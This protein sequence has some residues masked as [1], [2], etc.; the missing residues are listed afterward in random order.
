MTAASLLQLARSRAG[1]SQ[2]ELARRAHTSQA[3]LS[4]IEGGAEEP[5]FAQLQRLV[6]ACG[7][8]LEASVEPHDDLERTLADLARP[9][10]L[11]RFLTG[12]SLAAEGRS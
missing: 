6:A 12:V 2:R 10:E 8:R 9:A 3:R 4:R 5:S 11:S 1:I 7:L